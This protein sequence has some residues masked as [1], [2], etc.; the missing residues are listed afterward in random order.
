V[1]VVAGGTGTLGTLLVQRLVARSLPVRVLT[2]EP[3]RAGH[4]QKCHVDIV[5]ADVRDA[6]SVIAAVAGART[7]VSV[8]HGFTGAGVSPASVDEGGNANLIDAAGKAGAAFVLTSI[9]GAS[10]TSPMELFRAKYAAEQY[11]MRAGVPWTI[12][13]AT[14]FVETWAKIMADSLGANGTIPIFGRGENPINFVSAVDV[15]AV[16]EM[17]T[18]DEPTSGRAID[19]GGPDNL[20]FN[21]FAALLQQVVGRSGK[22]K[23]I[24]RTALRAIGLSMTWFKPELARLARAAMAMDTLP[25]TFDASDTRRT[26]PT[27]P[28]T[29][30]RTALE[31]YVR[32]KRPDA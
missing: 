22:V 11:L 20:T 3:S 24:P 32:C 29:D 19:L 13:R 17:V 12:V 18:A 25:M 21:A 14:A 4:L 26:F 7:V 16:L 5:T 6:A 8:I 15:A 30:V 10:P 27:L 9:V 2:R 31:H 28:N 1:I 23:H